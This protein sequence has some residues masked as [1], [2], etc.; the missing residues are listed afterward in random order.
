MTTMTFTS[1][2]SPGDTVY[3][4]NSSWVITSGLVTSVTIDLRPATGNSYPVVAYGIKNSN[5]RK[6]E[7]ELYTADEV[8]VVVQTAITN[9]ENEIANL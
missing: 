6:L 3:M 4:V 9:K 2:F 1:K 8:K 7:A 5:V